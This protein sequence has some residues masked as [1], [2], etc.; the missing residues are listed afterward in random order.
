MDTKE[1]IDTQENN[2]KNKTDYLLPISIVI[3]A[4]LISGSWIYSVGLNNTDMKKADKAVQFASPNI[5]NV[6]KDFS[7]D[8]VR[9]NPDAPVKIVEFS[10]MECPFCKKFHKTMIEVMDEY[11]KTG[12]V[13]WIYRHFPLEQLHPIKAQ[14]AAEASECADKLGGNDAFWNYLDGYFEI[15]PSNNQIDLSKLPEIAENIGLNK[16]QFESCLDSGLYAEKIEKQIK[17]AENSGANGTPYSIAIAKDGKKYPI[18]GALPY[19]Q[20]KLI[21]EEALK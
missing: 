19:E 21:I 2:E 6:N 13:A 18:N 3:A 1:N 14:K 8:H 15:T 17:D 11:G 12:K 4:L 10:D 5:E 7:Q 16:T 20:V 9:G